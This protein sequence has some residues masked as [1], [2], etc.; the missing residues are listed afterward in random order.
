VRRETGA[1]KPKTERMPMRTSL[2][3]R[4]TELPEP[5]GGARSSLGSNGNAML[6]LIVTDDY[7][8]MIMGSQA[9]VQFSCV[10]LT[11]TL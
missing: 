10:S 5:F 3:I 11:V 9:M 2:S 4:Q 1:E 6:P 8:L 7:L